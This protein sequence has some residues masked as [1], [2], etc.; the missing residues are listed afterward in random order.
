MNYIVT[1]KSIEV[2]SGYRRVVLTTCH[3]SNVDDIAFEV[4]HITQDFLDRHFREININII[5]EEDY[6]VDLPF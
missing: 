4:S 6:D 1:T 3:F 5:P 2:G